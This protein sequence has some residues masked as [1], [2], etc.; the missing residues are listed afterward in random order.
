M[1]ERLRTLR[2]S[3]NMSQVEFAKSLN[4][5]QNSY[6]QIETGKIAITDK[7]IELICMKYSVNKDWFITGI[8][9]MFAKND[10]A[11]TPEET[12]ILNIFR[13]LSNEMKE[14]MLDMG[15]KLVKTKPPA[16]A[17]VPAEAPS[18]EPLEKGEV[19][20]AS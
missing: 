19:S 14:F 4:M 18:A 13:N 3:L 11:K 2:K 15:R 10:I 17:E 20:K 7:N 6:S 16:P 12:E 1:N 5:A 8:G 9:E